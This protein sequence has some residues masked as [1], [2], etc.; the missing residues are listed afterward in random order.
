MSDLILGWQVTPNLEPRYWMTPD[1]SRIGFSDTDLF[2]VSPAGIGSHTAIIA[3]SGSGKSFFLG[4]VVEEILLR[5]K[6]RCL[7]FDPNADFRR[8]HEVEQESLWADTSPYN[9]R[10]RAGKIT[11]EQVRADFLSAWND[12]SIVIRVGSPVNEKPYQ[13]LQLA[14]PA[15]SADFLSEDLE[16]VQRSELYHCHEFVRAVYVLLTM[17]PTG[18]KKIDYLG[19]IESLLSQAMSSPAD[20]INAMRDE[21]LDEPVVEEKPHVL[22]VFFFRRPS[23]EVTQKLMKRIRERHIQQASA[24]ARYVSPEVKRYYFGRLAEF[25]AAQI[26]DERS[27]QSEKA[28]HDLS[29]VEV[30]DLP[31]L[32]SPT[33][34]LL[35]MSAVLATEWNRARS[36][37]SAALSVKNTDEDKRVPTFVIVDEA[38]N[39]IP[40][41]ARSKAAFALREQFRTIIAEGRKYGLFLILVSQ[42]PDKLDPLV[43]SECENRA[44]MRMTS[45][46]A[47]DKTREMLAL[48]DRSEE[49]RV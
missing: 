25:R 29:R 16:P 37:W 18:D 1:A 20:F 45:A 38:H 27:G 21:F 8:L 46:A 7:I 12:V 34:R 13:Q 22:G 35:A 3:Q 31:S 30:L 48:D 32:S 11:H 15:V 41:E 23:G 40:H 17:K 42:R 26:I 49:R 36:E 47:L 2:R 44:V 10:T 14:W 24:A 28:S 6:A 4:R 43:V 39:V 19:R 9:V 5:T 33:A